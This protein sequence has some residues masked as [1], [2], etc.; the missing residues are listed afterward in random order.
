MATLDAQYLL[1]WIHI[2][3]DACI[4]VSVPAFKHWIL[5]FSNIF[6]ICLASFHCRGGFHALDPW[7]SRMASDGCCH[8]AQHRTTAFH[9]P[10]TADNPHLCIWEQA[11]LSSGCYSASWS[12]S[13]Y[14]IGH[15][16]F[17]R[18]ARLE[19]FQFGC[20]CQ[21]TAGEGWQ[22]WQHKGRKRWYSRH[23]N[24]KRGKALRGCT[25][26]GGATSR[27]QPRSAASGRNHVGAWSKPRW[28][29]CCLRQPKSQTSWA[30]FLFFFFK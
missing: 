11:F 27:D 19:D 28:Q 12:G 20:A 9:S 26:P 30:N 2:H 29:T 3:L 4:W 23:V 18:V 16:A 6:L 5:I 15:S 7:V 22:R 14:Y 10:W 8:D 21:G 13:I 25:D 24:T 17:L 1:L